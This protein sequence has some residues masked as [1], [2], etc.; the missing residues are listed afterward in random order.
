MKIWAAALG[1]GYVAHQG[2]NLDLLGHGNLDVILFLP[3]EVAEDGVPKGADGGE[4]GGDELLLMGELGE[5]RHCLVARIEDDGEGFF[6]VL[7]VD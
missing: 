6:A 7:F 5:A 1:H 2:K 4:M 3:V